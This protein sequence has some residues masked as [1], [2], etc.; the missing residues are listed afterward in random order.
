MKQFRHVRFPPALAQKHANCFHRFDKEAQLDVDPLHERTDAEVADE[1][2]C[3]RDRDEVEQAP[4]SDEP[5]MEEL[6]HL[7]MFTSVRAAPPDATNAAVAICG[8][9][10]S[11]DCGEHPDWGKS[12]TY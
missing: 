8:D 11:W 7:D 10:V 6:R 9:N 1:E 12:T 2:F 3:V 5:F 4:Y